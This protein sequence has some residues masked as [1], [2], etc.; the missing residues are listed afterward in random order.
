[1][2]EM[3]L[4]LPLMMLLLT[5]IV[6]LGLA[7]SSYLTLSHAVDVGAR[8]LALSRGSSSTNPCADAVA[9]I[10]GAAP[11]LNASN[12]SYT[13]QIGSDTFTGKS[14]GFS[15]TGST[16]CSVLGVSDM[17]AGSTASVTANYP[18][19]LMI[20]FWKSQTL[21]LTAATSEVIQ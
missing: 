17:V 16:S 4:A 6:S 5:G 11:S 1:M 7:L 20:I 21:N 18:Y 3:A 10:Q 2:V 13:F 19:Q 15:G 8:N 9:L 12:V 14:N